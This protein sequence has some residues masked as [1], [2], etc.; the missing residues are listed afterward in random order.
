MSGV[1]GQGMPP[2]AITSESALARGV[3]RPS[4]SPR[5]TRML[6]CSDRTTPGA[7]TSLAE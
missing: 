5:M 2:A 1:T 4:G 6:P 7:T 3:T